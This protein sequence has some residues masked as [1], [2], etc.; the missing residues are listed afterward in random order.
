MLAKTFK[1][2]AIKR[3]VHLRYVLPM[4]AICWILMLVAA[5]PAQNWEGET[6]VGAISMF[7]FALAGAV[8]GAAYLIIIC[9]SI[10]MV[11]SLLSKTSVLQHG[12]RRPFA[13][14]LLVR[15]ALNILCTVLGIAL[16]AITAAIAGDA[17]RNLDIDLLTNIFYTATTVPG[18]DCE[19]SAFG[20]MLRNV[21]FF[22]T[23]IVQLPMF[24]LFSAVMLLCGNSPRGNLVAVIGLSLFAVLLISYFVLIALHSAMLWIV[25]I[26]LGVL[27]CWV[28]DNVAELRT[29][30]FE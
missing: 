10:G 13:V 9:P 19:L 23:F 21:M 14:I 1:W 7:G 2:E 24:F 4:V 28:I 3:G 18:C 5:N 8:L 25:P 11:G 30:L 6:Q 17:V 22:Y 20:L 15:I 16:I 26:S 12:N 27:A 29:N